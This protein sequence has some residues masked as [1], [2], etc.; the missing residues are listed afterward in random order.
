[1]PITTVTRPAWATPKVGAVFGFSNGGRTFAGV[2]QKLT[3]LGR[4]KAHVTVHVE[5]SAQEHKRLMGV[6]RTD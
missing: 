6:S 3:P 2:V 1:M 4:A 5:I